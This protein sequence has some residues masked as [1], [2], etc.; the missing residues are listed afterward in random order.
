[1]VVVREEQGLTRA[2]ELE[3][4]IVLFAVDHRSLA[5]F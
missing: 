5:G 4:R 2:E 1:M 3:E